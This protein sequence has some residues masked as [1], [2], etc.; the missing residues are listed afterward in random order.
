MK[1]DKP[2]YIDVNINKL[3]SLFSDLDPNPFRQRDLDPRA[4]QHIL[5]WASDAPTESKIILSLHITGDGNSMATETDVQQAV[6]NFFE[7]EAQLIE[8]QHNRN[9][10]RMLKWLA[11]GLGIMLIL[12]TIKYF[13]LQMWPDSYFGTVICEA[14]V[15][16]GWVSLWVPIERLGYDGLLVHEQLK[17][18][19]R[20]S[21]MEVQFD[22]KNSIAYK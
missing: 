20:L 16:M 10:N 21:V 17:L 15:I 8:R 3:D 2:Y 11:S 7:Y 5:Q 13:G 1:T 6:D 4:V 9:R 19:R 12:L 22:Q 14:F 18:Y